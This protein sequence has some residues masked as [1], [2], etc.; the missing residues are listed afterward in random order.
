[1]YVLCS[2]YHNTSKYNR[3]ST[4]G[5]CSSTPFRY[6]T[7]IRFEKLHCN[8]SRHGLESPGAKVN[9]P[10]SRYYRVSTLSFCSS[11]TRFDS[12]YT[13]LLV[14][15]LQKTNRHKQINRPRYHTHP[16]FHSHEPE[17]PPRRVEN[18]MLSFDEMKPLHA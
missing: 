6:C 8:N 9:E 12:L 5:F 10:C 14:S 7:P 2:R 17:P 18:L 13:S 11:S 1:M 16:A 3:V 4:L 15:S